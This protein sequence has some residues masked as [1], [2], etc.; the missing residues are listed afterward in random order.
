VALRS[1]ISLKDEV[2]LAN[3]PANALVYIWNQTYVDGEG[4]NSVD[5][6]ALTRSGYLPDAALRRITD[7]AAAP[8]LEQLKPQVTPSPA[9][10]AQPQQVTGFAITLGDHVMMR[11][12]ADTNAQILDVLQNSAVVS[13]RGQEFSAG[14]TWHLVQFGA[15]YGFVRADQ[16]RL[17][18]AAETEAYLES[19]RTPTPTPP[20][21]TLPPVTLDSPSSYGYVSANN[22]RLRKGPS[23]STANLKMMQKNAF[24]LVY[25]SQQQPD[26][27]WYHINQGGTEGYVMSSYFKVL[28]MGQLSSYLQS[29]EYLNANTANVTSP[30]LQPGQITSVE[31]YNTTVWQNPA[32]INP[33]YE[34]FNPLGTPTPPV[35]AIVSPSPSLSPSASASASAAPSMEPLPTFTV[36]ETEAPQKA[37][38]SFPVGWVAVGL[39]AILGGGGYYAY[40]L[41]NQNQKRA[42]QRAAQ[43]RQQAAR[44]SGAPQAR[45]AQPQQGQSPYAPPRPG[46]QPGA[47]A[48]YRP[49]M[50]TSQ[51]G[52]QGTPPQATAAYRPG[53]TPPQSQ[54]PA[55]TAP[56]STTAYRPGMTPPQGQ[57]S[58]GTAPQATTAYRPGAGQLPPTAPPQ[59][60][61]YRPGAVPPAGQTAPSQATVA[62]Q[63]GAPASGAPKP[64]Q[65]P[66]ADSAASEN[67]SQSSG[68][69]RPEEARRRRSDRHH[70]A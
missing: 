27:L 12:Y 34:P 36:V 65:A 25:G 50:P 42:A 54:P 63:P 48:P 57:P 49:G 43:R 32:L 55:G 40:H 11:A 15:G 44:Q 13:V 7:Q 56:Q 61:P 68:S 69:Q 41:Y 22:V 53:T 64:P 29:P 19:L 70:N 58:A 14:E 38:S 6:L 67:T 62:Y 4:W 23:T 47:T 46:Q 35:E 39:I 21:A 8:Y 1:G 18:S 2:I 17:L 37:D 51:P 59:R 52:Q 3:L 9:P 30:N 26:G 60:A 45:P 33:S 5:A 24:A 16:L 66:P 28:P 31:D 10:T 20:A